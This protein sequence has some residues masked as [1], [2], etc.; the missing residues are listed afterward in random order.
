MK[1]ESV[2]HVISVVSPP[3]SAIDVLVLY[4]SRFTTHL[5]VMFVQLVR[6]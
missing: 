6:I 3:D 5:G 2:G 1:A 4:S